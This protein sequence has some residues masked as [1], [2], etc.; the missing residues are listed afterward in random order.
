MFIRLPFA[1]CAFRALRSEVSTSLTTSI[2]PDHTAVSCA[3]YNLL[4]AEASAGSR[5]ATFAH[6]WTQLHR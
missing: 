5:T 1:C 4:T 2:A 6:L 3:R